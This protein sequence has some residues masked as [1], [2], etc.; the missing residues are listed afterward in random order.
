MHFDKP[1]RQAGF[2]F[3]FLDSAKRLREIT[4]LHF[5]SHKE[6]RSRRVSAEN[7]PG[8]K[9]H[10]T[11]RYVS[12][13]TYEFIYGL[14]TL[15]SHAGTDRNEPSRTDKAENGLSCQVKI[16]IAQKFHIAFLPLSSRGCDL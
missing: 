14:A 9:S 7:T 12:V 1:T 4:D 10:V 5:H 16:R 6:C 11:F 2:L 8:K 13:I 3:Y 15:P